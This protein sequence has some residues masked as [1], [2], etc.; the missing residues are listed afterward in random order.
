LVELLTV[1]AVMV[2]L[3]ALAIPAFTAIRGGADFS[4]EVYNITGMLD[5][6]R[7]YA[8]ANS[9]YVLAGIAEVSSAQDSAASPQAAG[10]GRIA[11]AIVAS[12]NGTRPYQSLLPNNLASWP[13]AAFPT[14][15]GTGSAFVP[16]TALMAFQ[17]IHMVD[18]QYNGASPLTVPASGK[19]SRPVLS[20]YYYDLP[21]GSCSSSTTFAWPMGVAFNASPQYSFSKVIEYDPQGSARIISISNPASY[22]EAIPLYLELGLEP[23]HGAAVSTPSSGQSSGQIA[24][25]QITGITGASHIY[26][27]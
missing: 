21:N 25:I 6:A 5:E 17:N 2:A 18:L 19:M 1:V 24:A 16:V 15:Y 7:S 3:M 9:T 22:P 10:T 23:A 8:V 27:P 11:V 20:S 12:K 26:R 14:G 4:S 13:T